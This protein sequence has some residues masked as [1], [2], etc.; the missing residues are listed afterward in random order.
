MDTIITK[1]ANGQFLVQDTEKRKTIKNEIVEIVVSEY[2][3]TKEKLLKI[4]DKI[5]ELEKEEEKKNVEGN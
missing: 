1:F 3:L 2:V 4:L 5:A